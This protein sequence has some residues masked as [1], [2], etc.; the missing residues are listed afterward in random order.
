MLPK[1]S[2]GLR[3]ALMLTL[4]VGY[5]GYHGHTHAAYAKGDDDSDS[6]SDDPDEQGGGKEGEETDENNEDDKDQPPV[7][8]GGLFT[9]KTYPV[10]EI[11]RPL[12][13]TQGITQVRLSVGTDLS[14]KGAF[15]SAGVSLEGQHGITDNF[16]LVGGFTSQY[17]TKAFS[18]Y[19]GFEASLYYDV[20]DF[21]LA[22]NYHHFALPLYCGTDFTGDKPPTC[23]GNSLALPDGNYNNTHA[24]LSLDIGFPFRYAFAPQ[25]AVVAL[26]TLM[27]V[28][29]WGHDRGDI[30][31]RP[32][33][34]NTPVYCSGVNADMTDMAG[35]PLTADQNNCRENGPKPDLNPSLG[36]AFNP[37]AALSVVVEAQLRVPDFDTSAGN[38]QVPVTG[39]VEFSP[40]Q[41]FDIGLEFTLVNVKPP[42]PQSPIDNRF[43]SLFA[44]ARF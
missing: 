32:D 20:V 43:L 29:F 4:A 33:P 24:Q 18:I 17:N 41:Q 7:T 15:G 9:I 8:A 27:S 37:I 2:R 35:N 11:L 26:R 30:T 10:N 40:N 5:I 39:R 28:D 44:Q 42:D 22:L 1:L 31:K 12:V 34:D 21:R 6:D 13:M 16:M 14:A 19:A 3:S 38:F 23:D 25:V 36:I